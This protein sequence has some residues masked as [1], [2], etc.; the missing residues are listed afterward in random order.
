MKNVRK[1]Y[2][3][4][5]IELLVAMTIM[6]ILLVI[7]IPRVNN[8][9]REYEIKKYE[10]YAKSV[11]RAAKLYTESHSKEM[12]GHQ[13]SGCYI[14]K[15]SDLKSSNLIKKYIDD[16]GY[17]SVE[18]S[19]TFVTVRKIS[20]QYEYDTAIKCYNKNDKIVLS[21]ELDSDN[22]KIDPDTTGPAISVTLI[23]SSTAEW[24]SL[25]SSTVD[26]EVKLEDN[27]GFWANQT[28]K[29]H[30]HNKA[31]GEDYPTRTLY[32]KNERSTKDKVL[33][34]KIPRK[35]L[36]NG[37]IEGELELVVEPDTSNN[38]TGVKDYLGNSTTTSVKKTLKVDNKAPS[39]PTSE[40]RVNNS[41]GALRSN[42]NSWTS[43]TRWWGN[44]K[45]TDYGSEIKRYEYL[46]G[47]SGTAVRTLNGPYTYS[48][49]K[50]T[51]YCIRAVDNV[52]NVSSWSSAYY[53]KI[54]KTDPAIKITAHTG[55]YT[56][57]N[58]CVSTGTNYSYGSWS[59]AACIT[60]TVE[61][62]DNNLSNVTY[63]KNGYGNNDSGSISFSNGKATWN[64]YMRAEGTGTLTINA[65][66]AANRTATSSI[67]MKLDRTK[68]N[69]IS[70]SN[71]CSNTCCAKTDNGYKMTISS[72]DSGSG[73]SYWQ[74]RKDEDTDDFSTYEN[75]AVNQYTTAAFKKAYDGTV[76]FKVCDVA[77]NCRVGQ[78]NLEIGNPCPSTAPSLTTSVKTVCACGSCKDKK[79]S[80]QVQV[81]GCDIGEGKIGNVVGKFSKK[82]VS[83]AND[84]HIEV[85]LNWHIWQGSAT[86]IGTGY[87]V[88]LHCPGCSSDTQTVTLKNDRPDS[89]GGGSDHSG[90]VTLH[91][92]KKKGTYSITVDGNS[93]DPS[94]DMDFPKFITIK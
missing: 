38:R 39:V 8:M 47:C 86:W 43:E 80:Y 49:N 15:Y 90:Q 33:T 94:F 26:V 76:S 4:T 5:L 77:G 74:R 79:S 45:S 6:G 53:F 17:C 51:T 31:T 37:E 30:W 27:S 10:T 24:I 68:P 20:D 7:A 64:G 62:T 18:D 61:V 93:S 35:Y 36:P 66:D 72:S 34:K 92:P 54:D 22:C 73:I 21:K 11:E 50:N 65:K 70:I 2:G 85:V 83:T 41:T 32:F 84:G 1:K 14:V 23:K 29:Y 25:D 81:S 75:S 3:F 82:S 67:V 87:Y 69:V 40:I 57:D 46:E 16:G 91:F 63:S 58:R 52:D 48:F 44:F 28:V 59:R 42:S 55:E 71:P 60:Y 56:N 12:F 88:Y 19:N 78:T 9:R 13:D 89:W